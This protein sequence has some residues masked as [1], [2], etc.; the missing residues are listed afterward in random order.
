[1]IKAILAFVLLAFGFAF[2]IGFF[3]SMT[4][5]EQWRLTKTIMYSILCSLLAITVLT[6]FV[7]L[8]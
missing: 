8:F 3:R 7:I 4:G 6:V 1:M 5:K 2:G